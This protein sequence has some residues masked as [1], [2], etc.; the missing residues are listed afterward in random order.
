MQPFSES[1]SAAEKG[2]KQPFSSQAIWQVKCDQS[3]QFDSRSPPRFFPIKGAQ[4][5]PDPSIIGKSHSTCDANCGE[6]VS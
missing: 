5:H 4:R 2:E 3:P 6:E 1:K